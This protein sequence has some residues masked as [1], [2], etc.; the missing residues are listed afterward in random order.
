MLFEKKGDKS[1]LPDL[2]MPRHSFDSYPGRLLPPREEEE[3]H[4]LPAFPDSPTHN[5]FS[6]AVIKDAVEEDDDLRELPSNRSE[7]IVE[8]EEWNPESRE[9]EEIEDEIEEFPRPSSGNIRE[10]R[11]IRENTGMD[12]DIFVKIDKFRNAKK[13]LDEVKG[14]LEE[15]EDLLRKIREAKLR[16]EQELTNW[17]REITQVKSRIKDVTDNI[18]SKVE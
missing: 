10:P 13:S 1:K 9:T 11:Y 18:F 14:R 16:E 4:S 12:R 17:E 6:Q 15:V 5:S 8:M 7:K 2:P 3:R